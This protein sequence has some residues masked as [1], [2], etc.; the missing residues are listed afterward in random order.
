MPSFPKS[1]GGAYSARKSMVWRTSANWLLPLTLIA[2]G[3]LAACADGDDDETKGGGGSGGTGGSGGE[4]G[5][6][7]GGNGGNPTTGGGGEGAT[8]GDGGAGAG[9]DGGG[10]AGGGE[11]GEGGE[12][13]GTGL[14]PDLYPLEEENNGTLVASNTL[15]DGAIGFQ[16]E[17]SSLNDVDVFNVFVPLGSSLSAVVTDGMG[18]CPA[19][20][21]LTVSIYAPDNITVVA[22]AS[23]LCPA[24]DGN[25]DPDLGEIGIEGTY[26]VRVSG[27]AAVP[28]YVME[29]TVAEP[30][31][32]D[33]IVQLSEQCDDGNNVAGDGC[34]NDCTET[35]ECGD[36]SVQTG[37]ECD[38]GDLMSGDGCDMNCD[39]EGNYCVETEPNNTTA[40]AT[41]ITVCEGGSGVIGM[42]T[43]VD[44]YEVNVV[45]P[46]SSIRAEV[47][48]ITG[49]GC[50]TGFDSLMT[51]FNAAGVSLGTDN[52]D[53]NANCSLINPVTDTFTR[54]LAMGT[55]FVRVEESGNNATS[56]QYVALIDVLVPGCGDGFVQVGEECDDGDLDN[57]D[58]CSSTCEIEGNFCAE[59]EPNN[60][61]GTAD[62]LAGCDGGS[63]VIPTAGDKDFFSFEVPVAGSSV[64]LRV[65]DITGLGC[66]ATGDPE[67]R[68]W[69]AGGTQLASD[70]DDS[71]DGL[72]SMITPLPIP[73]G[74]GNDAGAKN[75]PAGTYYVNVED[76]GNT[77]PVPPYVIRAVV[78][79][80]SC[81]DGIVQ[82]GEECDDG[83]LT[84]GDGCDEFCDVEGTFCTESEP[85]D[86]FVQA[87]QL[88]AACDGGFGQIN[89]ISDP[90]WYRFDVAVANSSVRLEVVDTVGSGCPTGFN[91]FIRLFN[92]SMTQLGSDDED[93]NASCS[94][95]TPVTDVFA[96][97]LAVGTYYVK[98]E[99]QG[100]DALSSPYVVLANVSAPGCGD[101]VVQAGEQC[102]DGNTV[103]ADS[104]SNACTVISCAPGQTVVHV[105]AM[106]LPIAIP[107]LGQG[108]ATFNVPNTGL[109]TKVGVLISLTHTFNIDVDITLDAPNAPV[110]ELAT[111]LSGS[112]YANTLFLSTA[113]ANITTGTA[114]FTGVWLPEGDFAQILGTQA[115]GTWTVTF[116]DD[117]SIG[118]GSVTNVSL[119]LCVSP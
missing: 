9:P 88:S 78:T 80:P 82:I 50:P 67:I 22:T 53:G 74:G 26:F 84:P 10:G 68:L 36:G 65:V 99:E 73:T 111:D 44:Y 34:E 14:D 13:G 23:A 60:T 66:P 18:G 2:L 107:D 37:E 11:G 103:D 39:L 112:N 94:L 46:G 48:D 12:G 3:P 69:D 27:A 5:Q 35:P 72:C 61:I 7:D 42:A 106:T 92:S 117:A 54:N 15:P 97:N 43:D 87:T 38:D 31:C 19:D 102:D 64:E 95:I 113:S 30:E 89:Y 81:G 75:L 51:L 86:T 59:S 105:P 6:P 40:T 62:A 96:R 58:G 70:D 17:L 109:V 91:S 110:I 98:V 77:D 24:L 116:A 115:S 119:S 85:N 55:Y 93:G 47:V 79:P 16:A 101:G 56:G 114:P 41:E 100:N 4:G 63:G 28:F 33:M 57:G 1:V 108:V 71:P 25:A 52:D 104:C 29:I 118:A 83:D 21:N 49:A 90:D 8:G 32:G 45:V 20:A 76:H